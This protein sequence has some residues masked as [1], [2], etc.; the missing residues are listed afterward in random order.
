MKIRNISQHPFNQDQVVAIQGY[1]GEVEVGEPEKKFFNSGVDV[2]ET[3]NGGVASLVAPFELVLDALLL[4]LKGQIIVWRADANARKRASFAARGI[5]I[6]DFKGDGTFEVAYEAA[7][8]PTVEGDFKTG[9][10]KPYAG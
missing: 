5:K 8:T 4:G 9:E 3:V 10:I 2:V 6:Y 7:I 1:Y